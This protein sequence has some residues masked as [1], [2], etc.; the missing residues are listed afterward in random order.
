M[1]EIKRTNTVIV[2]LNHQARFILYNLYTIEV[3]QGN[4][5]YYNCR[6]FGH[7]AR[8]CRNKKTENRIEKS[9]RLEY[10]K[11]R[12]IERSNEQNDNLNRDKDLIVLN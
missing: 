12:M 7:L 1:K 6:R 11:R 9:R 3:D 5:N 2:C 10:K 8:N 4:R